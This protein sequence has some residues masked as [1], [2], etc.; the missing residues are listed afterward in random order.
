MAQF[1]F[2]STTC[3]IG[4][5]LSLP[6]TR[7]RVDINQVFWCTVATQLSKHTFFTFTETIVTMPPGA[8]PIAL[9]EF[10]NL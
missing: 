2:L 5:L 4:T 7:M 8:S 10:F 1:W 6:T 3:T 9:E